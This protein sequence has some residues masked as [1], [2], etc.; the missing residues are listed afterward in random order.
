MDAYQST[1]ITN[2]TGR[3]FEEFKQALDGTVVSH[4]E[5]LMTMSDALILTT[6]WLCALQA[7]G[8]KLMIVGNGG[9]AGIASHMA[10]DFWKNAHVRA[11]AFNDS[12]L[13][14]ALGNDIGFENVFA[15]PVT[16]FGE[17]GD[18]LMCISSSGSS[19]NI[20][21]AAEAG[22]KRG[23]KV[24]TFSGFSPDNPLRT[25]GDLNFWVPA[26]SYGF[27]ESIHQV[28]IHAILDA[29]MFCVDGKDIFFKNVEIW[30]E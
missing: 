17:P 8:H 23:C 1:V 25:A 20:L 18:V 14:S 19:R 3:Y 22:R 27:A 11:T 24:I 5:A 4:G 10:L 26:F 2:F 30:T 12:S 21:L 16:M 6:D 9:S 13:L 28:L 15:A 29:K 7:S